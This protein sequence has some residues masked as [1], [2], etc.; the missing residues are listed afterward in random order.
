MDF[1]TDLSKT[2]EAHRNDDFAAQMKAYLKDKFELYGIKSG[3][4]RTLMKEV[5]NRH[6]LE[7]R[8]TVRVLTFNLYDSPYREMHM[9]AIELFEKHLRKHYKPEDIDLIEAL[10][11]TNSW[12]DSVDFIAKQILGRYLLLY[13]DV[14]K[15]I[16][17]KF[18]DAPD[19]WLN[20]SAI[21]FQLGYKDLTDETMLFNECLKH[22][23][24]NEF[25]IQKAIGWALRE[26]GK[27]NP[28]SVKSFVNGHSLAPLS[29]REALKNIP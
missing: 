5:A 14:K 10:I 19:M 9:C 17:S 11:T 21:I 22:R 1:I 8:D 25:F 26:Y 16:I 15:P 29:E 3:P 23:H 12:W 7:L 18:S 24:S 6:I 27:T 2:F 4:R 20:R 13:P 28:D